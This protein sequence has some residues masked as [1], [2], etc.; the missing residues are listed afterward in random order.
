MLWNKLAFA[1]PLLLCAAASAQDARCSAFHERRP[2]FNVAVFDGPPEQL[3]ALIPDVSRGTGDHAYASWD[4][5]YLFDDGRTLYLV[6]KYGDWGSK[7]AVTV[8]VEKKVSRCIYRTYH[9][10][11]PAELTCK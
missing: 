3:A 7:D 9:G 2:L 5:A 10:G 4:V 11:K 1:L 8:K 6:C